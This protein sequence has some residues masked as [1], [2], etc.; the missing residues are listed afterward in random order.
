ML[1]AFTGNTDDSIVKNKNRDF[2]ALYLE[3][4][5]LFY[6]IL[7]HSAYMEYDIFIVPIE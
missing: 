3:G 2:N 7:L 5:Y 6:H 4:V 1:F